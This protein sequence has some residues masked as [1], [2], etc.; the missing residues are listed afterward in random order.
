VLLPSWLKGTSLLAVALAA[1]IALGVSYERRRLSAHEATGAH[2]MMDRLHDE[3]GLDSQQ[4]QMIAAILARRQGALDSTWHTL[5]PH[6][7][8][9]LDSAHQEIV[10]VLRPEQVVKYRQIVELRH[11]GTAR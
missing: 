3:L 5:Q 1:G 10:D 6:V 4:R 9:T 7:R 11:H 8:A 2:H